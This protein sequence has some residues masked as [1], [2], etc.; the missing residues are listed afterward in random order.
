[1][2]LSAGSGVDQGYAAH[3]DR[4]QHGRDVRPWDIVKTD[5]RRQVSVFVDRANGDP[6]V[7]IFQRNEKHFTATSPVIG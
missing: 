7:V 1:M 2:N 6:E 3:A 4:Q 5:R